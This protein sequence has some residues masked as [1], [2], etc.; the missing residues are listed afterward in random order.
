L[1]K[2]QLGS[3]K[4]YPVVEEFKPKAKASSFASMASSSF[5]KRST[6]SMESGD[7][8]ILQFEDGSSVTVTLANAG[9]QSPSATA[10]TE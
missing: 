6:S 10:T 5:V 2:T 4:V 3:R 1:Q 7:E 8:C 9:A